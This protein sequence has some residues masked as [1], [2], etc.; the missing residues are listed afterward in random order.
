MNTF[1][2]SMIIIFI[3][4]IAIT[5]YISTKKNNNDKID[6]KIKKILTEPFIVDDA[7]DINLYDDFRKYTKDKPDNFDPENV[8]NP[9]QDKI[10]DYNYP[11]ADKNKKAYVTDIDF[12]A[13]GSVK[14]SV[15]CSNS[16]INHAMKSGPLQLLPSQIECDQPNKLTAENYYKTKFNMRSIPM[17]NEYLVKGANYQEYTDFVDPN[18]S[19]I[20]ILSQNTKGLIPSANLQKNIATGS[21][22]AFYGTPAMP[23]P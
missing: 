8:K 23:M 4:I 20:R 1:D 21:N 10:V 6:Q 9:P 13:S 12:G 18:K 14:Q 16:S 2:I 5:L 17:H 7:K 19:N 11:D 3:I 15:S 22:Y